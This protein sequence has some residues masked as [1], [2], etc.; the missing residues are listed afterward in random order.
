[1]HRYEKKLGEVILGEMLEIMV[2]KTVEENIEIVYRNDSYD[3]SRN[4]SRGRA[5]F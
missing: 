4:R 1:M 2:D 3:R 5:F